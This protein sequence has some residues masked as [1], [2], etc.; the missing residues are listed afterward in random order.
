MPKAAGMVIITALILAAAPGFGQAPNMARPLLTP[1]DTWTYQFIGDSAADVVPLSITIVA[2]TPDTYTYHSRTAQETVVL[3]ASRDMVPYGGIKA[4]WP[5]TV[6]KSWKYS[7]T[8]GGI[9]VV[10]TGTVEAYE[11][12]QVPAGAFSTFRIRVQACGVQAPKHACGNFRMWVSPR[13]KNAVKI[14]WD[15]DAGWDA[16]HLRGASA[17]L[18]SYTVTAP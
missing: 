5:L 17:V 7:Q 16:E 8:V 10:V 6:G 13:V 4:E 1:G 18:A 3:T 2:T 11:R 12:V 15:D 9:S 14:A